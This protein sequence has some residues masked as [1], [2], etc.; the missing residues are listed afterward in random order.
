MEW[1]K[2]LISKFILK[3]SFNSKAFVNV[4]KRRKEAKLEKS[5]TK[6]L[7]G[8]NTTHSLFIAIYSV[9]T[10]IKIFST[11]SKNRIYVNPFPAA[12]KFY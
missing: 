10:M 4:M 3:S 9:F 5:I 8:A 11:V 2:L 12:I 1:K 7:R 6:V